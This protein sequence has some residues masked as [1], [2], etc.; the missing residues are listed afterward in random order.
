[1]AVFHFE[2]KPGRIQ[3]VGRILQCCDQA[4]RLEMGQAAGVGLEVDGT[5]QEPEN[6][7]AHHK[8]H[9]FQV[10]TQFEE[11]LWSRPSVVGAWGGQGMGAEVLQTWR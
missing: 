8:K 7:S 11:A 2:R 5:R 10:I 3:A 1:M 4:H 6:L 9:T